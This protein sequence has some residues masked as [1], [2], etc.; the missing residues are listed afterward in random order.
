MVLVSVSGTGNANESLDSPGKNGWDLRWAYDCSAT[1]GRGV[2]FVD[3]FESDHTPDFKAP[4]VSEEG[5]RDSGDYH[6]PSSGR[7]YL[8][9]TTTCSW[10]VEAVERS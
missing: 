1:G 7:F 10:T 8:E 9:I 5:D 3:V 6:V 2:F 4:G